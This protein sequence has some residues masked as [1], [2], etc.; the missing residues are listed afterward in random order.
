MTCG[1][2]HL[3]CSNGLPCI[4]QDPHGGG[5]RAGDQPPGLAFGMAR[6]RIFPWPDEDHKVNTMVKAV[7][8]VCEMLQSTSPAIVKTD[9][10]KA[11][12]KAKFTG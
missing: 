7:M 3:R 4:M 12:A 11:Q 5:D 1:P 8:N 9:R 6:R 2:N 10:A